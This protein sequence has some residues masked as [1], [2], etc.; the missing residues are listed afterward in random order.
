MSVLNMLQHIPELILTNCQH[1]NQGYEMATVF[2]ER[3]HSQGA[4]YSTAEAHFSSCLIG[5]KVKCM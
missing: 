3:T 2:Q 5:L 1:V 4:I